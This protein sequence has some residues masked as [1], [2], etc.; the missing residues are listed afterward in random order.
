MATLSLSLPF[1]KFV[2]FRHLR[3]GV[4]HVPP[5][6]PLQAEGEA[7]G[8][9]RYPPLQLPNGQLLHVIAAVPLLFIL[10]ICRKVG[11]AFV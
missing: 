3:D 5:H 9:Y 6:H 7:A 8:P 1:V 4:Q 10:I 11:L 2:L